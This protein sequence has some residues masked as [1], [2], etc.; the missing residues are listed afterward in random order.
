MRKIK[1]GLILAGG[2]SSRFWPLEE[3]NFFSFLNKPLILYQIEELSQYSEEITIVASKKNATMIKRLV[4]NAESIGKHQVIIQKD[5][6]GQAG[7]ILSVKNLIK[8]EVLVI[9]AN[10]VLDM[11][12][13]N[14]ITKLSL[15]KNKLIF[16]G[17]KINEYFSGG[18]FRF[19]GKGSV[20]EIVEKPEKNKTPS[21]IVKLMMDYFSDVDFLIRA[22]EEAKTDRDD[23]YEVALNKLLASQVDRE[24][25]SYDGYWETIK[26]PWHVLSMTKLFLSKIKKNQ[27]DSSAE[28]SKQAIINGPVIIEKNVK[29]GDF[30][31]IT[32]PTYIGENSIIGDYSLIRE[33]QIGQD[34]LVGSYSEVARSYIGNKVFLHRN[35]VG[36]SV[37]GDKVMMGAQAVTANLRFDGETISSYYE[38]E[39]IDTNFSKLGVIIGNESKIGVNTTIIPGIKIGKKTWVAPR[40]IVR[41]DIEENTYL[42]GGEEKINSGI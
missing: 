27:I 29:I 40:E 3:K 34:C 39:K 42:S 26:Y 25:L 12:V 22:I 36:D 8:G 31:K 18:Y 41:Y 37:L 17:K 11:S 7:A 35:Y 2:D 33:S 10:D 30:V 4:E 38:D 28:I 20:E 15:P 6:E 32:G 19:N 5:I 16:F 21:N 23:H 13:L 14:K 9:N 24:Y 1:N